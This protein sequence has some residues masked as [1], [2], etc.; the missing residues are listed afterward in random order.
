MLMLASFA[1]VIGAALGLRFKVLILL[2]A[3]LFAAL[4]LVAGRMVYPGAVSS[5][6]TAM[7]YVTVGLQVGY[8]LGGV[9]GRSIL[10]QSQADRATQP[11]WHAPKGRL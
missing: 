6:V 4:A 8:L 1:I 5:L 7:V 2:P 9:A 11:S 10:F 3:I